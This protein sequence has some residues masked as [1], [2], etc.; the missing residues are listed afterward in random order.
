MLSWAA[1][2]DCSVELP[3]RAVLHPLLMWSL[4]SCWKPYTL[5]YLRRLVTVPLSGTYLAGVY[6]VHQH[7]E[8]YRV[9]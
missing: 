3:A 6:W 2:V 7:I 5:W 9:T 8:T 1:L 4:L